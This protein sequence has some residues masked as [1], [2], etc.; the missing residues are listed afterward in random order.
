MPTDKNGGR[1]FVWFCASW[2]GRVGH[3]HPTGARRRSR[4]VT[5][6][7]RRHY[8][9]SRHQCGCRWCWPRPRPFRSAP[10]W[11]EAQF[12]RPC[13]L[14]ADTDCRT[15]AG[16]GSRW[17]RR[18]CPPSGFLF[19]R[20]RPA[21]AKEARLPALGRR[22]VAG[23]SQPGR[24]PCDC[25]RWNGTYPAA[26]GSLWIRSAGQPGWSC[27][28]AVWHRQSVVRASAHLINGQRAAGCPSANPPSVCK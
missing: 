23:R 6:S 14:W 7:R 15:C 16:R 4:P 1:R 22:S 10:N 8:G 13:Q 19:E 3:R 11:C 12:L 18:R 9:S 21:D 27:N 25:R 17:A 24:R 5:I 2:L 20:L 28:E 26:G